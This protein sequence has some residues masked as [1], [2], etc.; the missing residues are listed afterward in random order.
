M[1]EWKHKLILKDIHE[2]YH[3]DEITAEEV[4]KET[5]KRIR[6]LLAKNSPPF[7]DNQKEEAEDIAWCFDNDVQEIDDYDTLLNE[8]YD[9]ADTVLDHSSRISFSQISRLCWVETF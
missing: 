3:S 5:A 7:T 9:W 6:E 8:L 2:R 4:G 1:T